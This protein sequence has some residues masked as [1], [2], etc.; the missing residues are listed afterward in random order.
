MWCWAI[1]LPTP[2]EPECRNNH[3]QS[4]S[5]TVTSMKW[6]L[7]PRV[8]SCRCRLRCR[9]VSTQASWDH[10]SPPRPGPANVRPWVS[11][12]RTAPMKVARSW[13]NSTDSPGSSSVA[14]V[15][16]S[17]VCTDHGSGYPASG[18]PIAT[19]AGVGNGE[20]RSGCEPQMSGGER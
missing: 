2:R 4:C 20:G 14:T 18:S 17:Q 13:A 7:D 16:G 11:I 19:G 10:M 1:L 5:S 6:S 9:Q 8:P 3:T 12:A 15:P